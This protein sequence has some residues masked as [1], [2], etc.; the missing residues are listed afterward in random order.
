MPLFYIQLLKICELVRRR[1]IRLM[2]HQNFTNLTK[3]VVKVKYNNY[4]HSRLIT[5]LI[6]LSTRLDEK[7]KI[8]NLFN[9]L[10]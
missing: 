1:L 6:R 5:N 3:L 10:S 9:F 4:V 7:K 8:S 2:F